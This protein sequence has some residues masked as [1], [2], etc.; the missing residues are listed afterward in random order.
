M[1]QTD[2]PLQ[3]LTIFLLRD[4]IDPTKALKAASRLQRIEIDQNHT[5]F[6]KRTKARPPTWT[7]FFANRVD[8]DHFGR[9]KSAAA[10]LICAS[11]SRH[12]AVVFGTGRYLLDLQAIEQRFGLLTT[13]NAVDPRKVRSIDKSSLDR[14]GMQSRI[15]ASRDA[16]A[17]DFGLDIE[18]DLVRAVA[19]MPIDGLLGETIAGFDSLH[20]STRIEFSELR[21]RLAVYLAKSQQTLYRRE[22]GW[23]DHI[24]E[25]RDAKI[26]DDLNRQLVKEIKSGSPN[27]C[28]MAPDGIIDWNQIAYFQF[29]S[30]QGAP[31]FSNLVLERFIDHLGGPKKLTPDAIERTRVRALDANDLPLHEWPAARCLQAELQFGQ[32][33]YLLSS[34]KWYQVDED[35]VASVDSIVRT[36]PTCSLG[37]PEYE[38]AKEG[39]Y[40]KRA[41]G[42][43]RSHLACLDADN[44]RHGGGQSQIEFCDLYSLDRDIIHVKRYSGSGVLSHLFSQAAVSGQLFKSDAEFR[45]KVNEKLPTSHRLADIRAVVRQDEYRVVIVI[46]GGP[47]TALQLPFFSRVTLKNSYKLLD[48]YGYRVAVSHVSLEARFARLSA[49]RENAR[50]QRPLKRRLARGKRAPAAA[51]GAARMQPK[52]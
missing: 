3:A 27:A 33:S 20:V 10:V 19:G 12:F 25:V 35:F 2:P 1:A 41:A 4:G 48:A 39:V 34:G 44:V 9:V 45:R 14:Q 46:V 36:I 8:P 26:L 28:W 40:N 52:P 51:P 17:K 18:Q 23:I 32:K 37:L 7:R 38:D 13:L 22:F 29:G 21:H 42:L 24:R 6:I 31:R 50:R 11:A 30:A 43:S 5:L 49:I 16:S 47:G 15:Q